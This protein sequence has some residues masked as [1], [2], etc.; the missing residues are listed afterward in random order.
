MEYRRVFLNKISLT[1]LTILTGCSNSGQQSTPSKEN[2]LPTIGDSCNT[3]SIPD[4]E[5][6]DLPSSI[7]SD[8]AQRFVEKFEKNYLEN[9]M[10][11]QPNRNF[12]GFDGWDTEIQQETNEGYVV[13]I[14]VRVDYSIKLSANEDTRTDLGSE[15]FNSVYY[16]TE[17]FVSRSED[18]RAETPSDSAWKTVACRRD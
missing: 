12:I 16:V 8:S 4:G 2:N 17:N 10:G 3:T 11:H 1:I 7:S 9:R 6:P 18:G 15:S 13:S 14:N 5:Y